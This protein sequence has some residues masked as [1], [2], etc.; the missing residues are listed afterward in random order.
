MGWNENMEAIGRA[1]VRSRGSDR[2]DRQVSRVP[3]SKPLKESSVISL[4]TVRVALA[5][6]VRTF[7]NGFVAKAVEDVLGL[8]GKSAP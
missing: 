8:P 3:A 2:H 7:W 5:T 1:L 4:F 6:F